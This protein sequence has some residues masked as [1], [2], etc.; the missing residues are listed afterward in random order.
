MGL[1]I[2]LQSADNPKKLCQRCHEIWVSRLTW[3]GV[4][5]IS[6]ELGGATNKTPW[7]AAFPHSQEGVM[8]TNLSPLRSVQQK[9][10]VT[11][12]SDGEN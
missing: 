7:S 2:Q 6:Q 3:Q 11:S 1:C 10:D 5:M 4:M 9:A 8:E 12:D